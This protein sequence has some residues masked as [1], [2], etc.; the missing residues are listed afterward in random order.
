MDFNRTLQVAYMT[1]AKLS[2]LNYLK[3]NN[4]IMKFEKVAKLVD[5]KHRQY[6]S[7]KIFMVNDIFSI[8]DSDGHASEVL[9]AFF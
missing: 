1:N 4:L 3:L 9:E 5:S 8:F 2:E 7:H 6:P